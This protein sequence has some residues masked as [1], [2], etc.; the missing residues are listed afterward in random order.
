[1]LTERRKADRKIM[2]EQ[3]AD[4]A[5]KH[6]ASVRIEICEDPLYPREVTVLL[7]LAG[8]ALGVDFQQRTPQAQPDTYMLSWH[9]DFNNRR[10]WRFAEAFA[11]GHV[12][13]YH[14]HKATDVVYGFEALKILLDQ[15]LAMLADGS[16]FEP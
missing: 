3:V 11:P 8:V 15:K 7:T 5:V 14:R 2:A 4:L 9:R 6:G 13:T 10:E 12:N 16:A 1:M